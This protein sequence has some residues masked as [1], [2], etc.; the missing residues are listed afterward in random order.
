M[1]ILFY[2]NPLTEIQKPRQKTLWVMEWIPRLADAF[3]NAG[4]SCR[5]TAVVSSDVYAFLDDPADTAVDDFRILSQ[6]D[7][8]DNY[9]FD[10]NLELRKWQ[11]GSEDTEYG[12]YMAGL[13]KDHLPSDYRPDLVVSFSPAPF[14]ETVFSGVPVLYYEYGCFSRAPYP[15]TFYLDPWGKGL[16][17]FNSRYSA[18]INDIPASPDDIEKLHEYRMQIIHHLTSVPEVASFFEALRQ[19]YRT[20]FL[21][22]L[23][24]SNFYE[25]DAFSAYSTQFEFVEHVL[26]SVG[27]DVGVLVT[28]HPVC[29]SINDN[30]LDEL[31]RLHPNLI[32]DIISSR[33][34]GFSQIA[35]AYVDGA[36]TQSSTVGLQAA[37]LNRYFVSVGSYFSGLADCC[38]LSG[39][40][41]MLK[42]E[43]RNKDNFFVWN[44]THYTI[45]KSKFSQWA[46][47]HIRM[48]SA[49]HRLPAQEALQKWKRFPCD[50]FDDVYLPHVR[51]IAEYYHP[52]VKLSVSEIEKRFVELQE[53]ANM[54]SDLQNRL[55]AMQNQ[56]AM[57]GNQLTAMQQQQMELLSSNFYR[58]FNKLHN[59]YLR[60]FPCETIRGRMVRKM[61][62]CGIVFYKKMKHGFRI[63]MNTSRQY[64]VKDP[65]KRCFKNIGI[66]KLAVPSFDKPRVSIIIPVYN[67]FVYTYFCIKSIVENAGD[68]PY[69]IIVADDCSTDRTKII[70]D[71][72]S[73]IKVCRTDRNVRF[74]LN[75]NHA[76]ETAQGEFI[77]FL[78]NDTVVHPGWL[79]SM[80]E[81]MDR[82]PKAGI[83]G[84]KLV[85]ANGALQEA[86][87]I[88]FRDASAWNYGNGE[89]P[90]D[91]E[92]NY[93]KECDYTSG[94]S[95]M[96]RTSLWK[97]IG[98][99]D[100]RF[101]PAYYEDT[102]LCFEA[103]RH[104]FKVVYQPKAAVTHFEGRSNGTD[105][106]GGLKKYQVDNRKKFADKWKSVL[107]EHCN[108]GDNVF[109][110][111]DRS[112][113][114]QHIFMLDHYV[115]T[116]D[117]D[118]GSRQMYCYVK[119]LRKLGYMIHLLGDNRLHDEPY[120]SAFQQLGVEVLYG[121]KYDPN[122]LVKWFGD[123]NGFISYA[124]LNRYHISVNY[125]PLIRQYPDIKLVYYGHDVG[126]IRLQRA[127]EVSGDQSLLPLIESTK[128]QEMAL[129]SSSDVNMCVGDFEYAYLKKAFPNIPLYNMPIFVYDRFIESFEPFE[130]RKDLLFVGGFNHPP[131]KDGVL[132]FVKDILPSLIEHIPD[133]R[134]HIVGSNMPNEIRKLEGDHVV[135]DGFV[136]DEELIGLYHSCRVVVAPLR[137][138]A[139]VKGKII[140]ALYNRSAVV[141][142]S[143]GAEGI[144]SDN[145]PFAIAD[146]PADFAN[147]VANVYTDRKLWESYLDN[148][149][150]MIKSAYSSENA[151]NL[152]LK[153][154]SKRH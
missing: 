142:T 80:V 94:A 69:E 151:V 29:K 9:R 136:S 144:P 105:V 141:T 61:V 55:A 26:D 139:G 21:V 103:R 119:I 130:K 54:I 123:N 42:N 24:Y 106:S 114:K 128:R 12:Q 100:E 63:K 74:L 110:A 3:R 113:M 53:Q 111:R 115:P 135:I 107:A 137:Y 38:S 49:L 97:E 132:W 125:F 51:G 11:E 30:S 73:N 95:L 154:F 84:A 149:L 32:S 33:V 78:N 47:D 72:I 153:I 89:N 66:K 77:L 31:K 143:I 46:P 44:L 133:I 118:A 93:L 75:C 34:E 23:G 10:G 17:A 57:T 91:P 85:Y 120:T 126:H 6:R 102:D 39:I 27:D 48:V 59:I 121:G 99:F 40:S 25:T 117:R 116:F 1:N 14:F 76:A 58:A 148:S 35:L 28:Q 67:Q 43:V 62:A 96:I 41:D 20:I 36:I 101:A 60:L 109:T 124:F 68:V 64:R 56:L 71:C 2:V 87:G 90:D 98:G 4:E 15:E 79:S 7:M 147:A 86:G 140:E 50:V 122:H 127:F 138:G 65:G 92:Y 150:A 108:N 45:P 82:I 8:L 145:H 134:F 16:R 112:S 152:L 5:I 129:Y 88:V 81:T 131:N 52:V 37:F 83:V 22:P 104:G 13:L 146:S 19:K 70:A 18:R